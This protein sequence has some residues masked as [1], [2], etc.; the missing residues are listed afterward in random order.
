VINIPTHTSA[1][2]Q[3]DG[4]YIRRIATD[5]GIPLLT[6]VQLTKRIVESMVSE[7]LDNLPAIKWPDILTNEESRSAN[8]GNLA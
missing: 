5:H 1:A 4:Y 3:T 2:E 8:Y 6:N 7:D